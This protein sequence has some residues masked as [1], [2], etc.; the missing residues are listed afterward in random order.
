[1]AIGT[2]IF[3]GTL[4]P[5]I[6]NYQDM[7]RQLLKD[8]PNTG[9][10]IAGGFAKACLHSHDDQRLFTDIDIYFTSETEFN[11]TIDAI[12][13]DLVSRRVF[14]N[15]FETANAI[16]FSHTTLPRV[17]FVRKVFGQPEDVVD[18]FD[19]SCSRVALQKDGNLILGSTYDTDLMYTHIEKNTL[20]RI[21]KY[22]NRYA[23]GYEYPIE[24]LLRT[25]IYE[26]ETTVLN[27][28]TDEE[29]PVLRLLKLVTS[30]DVKVMDF[31]LHTLDKH[32]MEPLIHFFLEQ[33]FIPQTIF[34]V[35]R[36]RYSLKTEAQL[37]DKCQLTPPDDVLDAY[38]EI[39]I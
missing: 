18:T 14:Y 13:S 26:P 19:L 27:Y 35:R 30:V 12:S 17:Q 1:M 33:N 20:N 29:E 7:L 23:Y 32:K 25:I 28:Y 39:F 38:P 36:T 37:Y 6:T 4:E 5:Q 31:I 10:F 21:I 16:T 22:N 24:K 11:K 3:T 2:S 34:D 9:W 15:R 8:L